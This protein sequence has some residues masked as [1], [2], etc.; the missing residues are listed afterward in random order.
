[1]KFSSKKKKILII[2]LIGIL[3]ILFLNLYQKDV[4]NFFYLFSSPVQKILW[5]TG[6]RISVFFET[7]GEIKNLKKENEELKLKIKE[8]MA[9]NVSLKELKKENEVLRKALNIGLEKEFQLIFS[10]VIG[11]DISGDFLLI[12]KG[13]KDGLENNLPVITQQ[14]SLVGKISEVYENFSKVM[15]ISDKKSSFDAKIIDIEVYGL[16]KGKGNLKINLE[17]L[18]KDKEI[19]EGDRVVTSAIG[20]IFPAGILVGEIEKVKKSD[21]KPFQEV[22]IKPTFDIKNLDFLFVIQK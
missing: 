9:E 14:K 15:L 16:I 19:K 20:G 11:K 3:F 6:E 17:L 8:L 21:I 13:L 7:I 18:P 22:E 10:E 5:K 1:M 12:N 2:G 4:K